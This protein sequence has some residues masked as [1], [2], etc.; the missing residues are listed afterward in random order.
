M[1]SGMRHFGQSVE[2]GPGLMSPHCLQC[3]RMILWG[4]LRQL[5]SVYKLGLEAQLDLRHSC[6]TWSHC[7][8]PGGQA[9]VGG[10]CFPYCHIENPRLNICIAH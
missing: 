4:Q 5:G 6:Q 9:M 3:N 2:C 10:G 7:R 1:Q 8:L